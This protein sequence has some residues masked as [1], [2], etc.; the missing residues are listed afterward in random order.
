MSLSRHSHQHQDYR[1]L[2]RPPLM[3]SHRPPL[4]STLV[5]KADS[6]H[7]RMYYRLIYLIRLRLGGSMPYPNITD[8]YFVYTHAA[9]SLYMC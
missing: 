3:R 5:M 1:L 8:I 4:S 2:T 9:G 6:S 7:E